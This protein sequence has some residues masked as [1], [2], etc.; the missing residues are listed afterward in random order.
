MATQIATKYNVGGV[1][2]DRPFKVRRLGHFGFNV[3]KVEEST[4]FYTELL[5]FKISDEG[6]MGR[7]Y[8]MRFGTD[9]HAFAMFSRVAMEERVR[10][11]P[12][13]HQLKPDATINQITWQ[14][15]SLTEPTDAIDYLKER[16][17]EL[18][19]IGRDGAGSNWATYFYDPDGHHNELYYGIEQIGWDGHSKPE[20]YRRPQGEKPKLPTKS[21]FDEVQES[22][23]TTGVPINGG[24]RYEDP[25]PAI[26]NVGGIMLGR[27]FKVV[28]HGPVNVFVED[29]DR[30]ID[31]YTRIVGHELTEEVVWE[32]KKC[33]FMRCHGEHHVLGLFPIEWRERLGLSPHTSCM[34]FG[35]QLANYQQLKDA[36]GFLREHGVRVETEL[37]PP[38]LQPGIDYSAHCFDPEGHCLQLYYYMEQVGRD[39]KPRSKSQRRVVDPGNWPDPLE[40]MSDTFSGEPYLGPWG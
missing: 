26:Y 9:H 36:I 21:E 15:Q 20:A 5:G 11:N 22:V 24:Y 40:P 17:I 31:F 29:V 16:G 13:G 1:L 10:Q 3:T 2:L 35:I 28:K 19:R 33:A 18:G 27:P 4:R 30:S 34:S 37:I 8:F 7:G 23:A 39:G 6:P 32:G 12:N 14:T 25:M 38:E